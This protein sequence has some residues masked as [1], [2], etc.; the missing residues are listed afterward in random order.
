L[1]PLQVV[2][3]LTSNFRT[4]FCGR[5]ELADRQQK[6]GQMLSRLKKVGLREAGADIRL[7]MLGVEGP[8]LAGFCFASPKVFVVVQSALYNIC[9]GGGQSHIILHVVPMCR[10]A[11]ATQPWLP[12][13]RTAD[14]V[15]MVCLVPADC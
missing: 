13:C 8:R 5:G 11:K 9:G 12:T 10:S 14:C 2:D 4:D 7:L 3:S 1:L 6:L 15:P